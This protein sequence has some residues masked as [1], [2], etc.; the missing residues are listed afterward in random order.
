M[1]IRRPGVSLDIYM[2]MQRLAITTTEHDKLS[3]IATHHHPWAC[4][5]AMSRLSACAL[6]RAGIQPKI[7]QPH[8]IA[9]LSCIERSRRCYVLY[10]CRDP[11]ALGSEP[12]C[13][14]LST[15]DSASPTAAS[16]QS[17]CSAPQSRPSWGVKQCFSAVPAACAALAASFWVRRPDAAFLPVFYLQWQ[18]ALHHALKKG[19]K[20]CGLQCAHADQVSDVGEPEACCLASPGPISLLDADCVC[21]SMYTAFPGCCH[22]ASQV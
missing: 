7:L 9:T 22:A 6:K 15:L 18:P 16:P 1:H 12:R 17:T 20:K 14:A 19:P 4:T 3:S 2:V 8:S 21:R 13:P 10:T 5:S 11:T